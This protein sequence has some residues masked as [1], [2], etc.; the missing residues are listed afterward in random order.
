MVPM[1]TMRSTSRRAEREGACLVEEDGAHPA[2]ALER[3]S[4]LDD[5]PRTRR[6]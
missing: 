3:C 6:P 5:D 2:E 4:T 1:P